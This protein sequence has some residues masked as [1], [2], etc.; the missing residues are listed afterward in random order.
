LTDYFQYD[1]DSYTAGKIFYPLK[2]VMEGGHEIHIKAWD[3]SN[4]SSSAETNFYVVLNDQLVIRDLLNYPNPFPT[5]TE[6]TF[7]INLDS[8][9]EIKIYTIAGR[10]IRVLKNLQAHSGFNHFYWDGLDQDQD[11]LANGVYLY[12]ICANSL[13]GTRRLFRHEIQKCVIVR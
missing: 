13:N 10:L 9:V 5:G 2:N 8:D 3:N 7:W 11:L 1:Q 12:K 4:N 6:F